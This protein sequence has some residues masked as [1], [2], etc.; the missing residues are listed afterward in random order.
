[1]RTK[2]HKQLSRTDRIKQRR[3]L[4]EERYQAEQSDTG[5][6]IVSRIHSYRKRD[7]KQNGQIQWEIL[8]KTDRYRERNIS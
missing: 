5:R 2:W 6:Q 3:Q 1:M 7:I 8:S 4:Q